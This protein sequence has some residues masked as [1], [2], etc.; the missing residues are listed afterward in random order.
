MQ[1]GK[2]TLLLVAMLLIAGTAATEWQGSGNMNY[3]VKAKIWAHIDAD[4]A[5]A[6]F[7]GPEEINKFTKN[8]SND[9]T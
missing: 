7:F 4:L 5:A 8:L 1:K 3:L 2:I 9:L 6:L